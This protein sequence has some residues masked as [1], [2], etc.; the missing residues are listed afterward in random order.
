MITL[1]GHGYV[2][3]HIAQELNKQGVNYNWITHTD[4]VP[5]STTII[6]A[7]GYTG[8]PNVDA[9]EDKSEETIEGNVT[10]PLMLE[11]MNPD[12]P[13]VHISSGCV[14]TGYT[15]GGWSEL[16]PPNFGFGVGSVYSGSKEMFQS[17][18]TPYLSKSYLLRIRMPFGDTHD[19]RNLLTKFMNYPKLI[20]T[21]NSLSCIM[22]VARVAVYFAVRK[23]EPGIYNV[24]NPGS[25]T[26][27]DIADRMGL[28]KQWFTQQEFAAVTKAPRSNCTLNVDK[29]QRVYPI[30]SL[31][32]ALDFCIPRFK[33]IAG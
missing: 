21:H 12:T 15:E 3:R 22:D 24:C 26:T 20:D 10:W 1:I 33:S 27:R 13:I 17:L 9:C 6:N 31:D 19:P 2:G 11:G 5:T 8:S 25:I 16:D 32:K 23:P 4:P 18:V 7:A 28:D 30:Q 29:L 14:Y